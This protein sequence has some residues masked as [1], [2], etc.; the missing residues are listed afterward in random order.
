MGNSFVGIELVSLLKYGNLSC[1]SIGKDRD[2]R[3]EIKGKR[4]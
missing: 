3:L 1:V 2:Q 4:N